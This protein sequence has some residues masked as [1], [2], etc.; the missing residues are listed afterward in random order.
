M[1]EAEGEPCVGPEPKANGRRN[2]EAVEI[3][4]IPIRHSAIV[5]HDIYSQRSSICD[6]AIEIHARTLGAV[7]AE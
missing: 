4:P 2:A 6:N 7:R 5:A 3:D 1:Q